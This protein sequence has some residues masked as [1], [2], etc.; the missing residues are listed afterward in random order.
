MIPPPLSTHPSARRCWK[1]RGKS[2]ARLCAA[3]SFGRSSCGYRE[4]EDLKWKEEK[5]K[6]KAEEDA[7]KARAAAEAAEAARREKEEMDKW[8]GTFSIE[9]GG[10]GEEALQ[11]ESQVRVVV[12]SN[13]FFVSVFN[14]GVAF[15]PRHTQCRGSSPS[16]SHTSR[17]RRQAALQLPRVFRLS[18]PAQVVQLDALAD[19]FK[20]TPVEVRWQ[21]LRGVAS[22]AP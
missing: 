20:L 15:V 18:T 5:Q 9:A 14:L 17:S 16:S 6:E 10:T 4:A 11:E 19:V 12:D 3:T 1:L 13:R 8:I 7:E 2:G 22:C 21:A